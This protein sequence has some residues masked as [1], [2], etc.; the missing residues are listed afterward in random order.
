MINQMRTGDNTRPL[1]SVIVPIYKVEAYIH[2]C[3][4]SIINQSYQDIEIILV[5]DGSPDCCPVICD[6]YSRKY[7]HI[8]VIHKE[9]G[10]ASSARKT[11]LK[12]A[13]GEYVCYV[14]GDDWIEENHIQCLA[15]EVKRTSA[16]IVIHG[17]KNAY[18]NRLEEFPIHLE[19]GFYTKKEIDEKIIPVMLSSN[20]FYTF[21]VPPSVWSKA[22][23]R[24]HSLKIQMSVPDIFTQGEDTAVTYP[25][26]V[27]AETISVIYEYGYMYRTHLN[28]ITKSYDRK[29]AN[30]ILP[31]VDYLYSWAVHSEY[32]KILLPQVQDYACYMFSYEFF[33][34]LMGNASVKEIVERL[35]PIITDQLI[36][37][38]ISRE[39]IPFKIKFLGIIS[40]RKAIFPV[41]I[42]KTIYSIKRGK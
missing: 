2:Q 20:P 16:D 38:S 6:E 18:E 31:L 25:M 40:K 33:N 13:K 42:L 19:A 8:H 37:T 9:N 21:T 29:L 10:G 22:F 32:S 11:G 36:K 27:L 12:A 28:A 26:I 4:D 41:W 15:E 24:D 34:E 14:D 1:F 30:N 17:F 3:V 23:R 7:S 35:Y 39:N 5:D